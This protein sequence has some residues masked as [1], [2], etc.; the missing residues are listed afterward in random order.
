MG[1]GD[2]VEMNL[3]IPFK[4]GTCTMY[5]CHFFVYSR[6]CEHYTPDLLVYLPQ[7]QSFDTI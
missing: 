2:K 5:M 6:R 4:G 7:L 3:E 1:T